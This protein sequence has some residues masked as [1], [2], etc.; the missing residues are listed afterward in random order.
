MKTPGRLSRKRE[1]N[2]QK[3]PKYKLER[4]RLVLSGFELGYLV[5]LCDHGNINS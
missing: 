1:D 5:G 2:I 4:K 3:N